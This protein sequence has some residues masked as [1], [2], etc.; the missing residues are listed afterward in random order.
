M[1]RVSKYTS[2]VS[3]SDQRFYSSCIINVNADG[4][5]YCNV[6][7]S[8]LP[9]KT[10]RHRIFKNNRTDKW[11]L[12]SKTKSDLERLYTELHKSQINPEV[13]TELVIRYSF[14]G[15]ARWAENSDGD[16]APNAVDPGYEWSDRDER[17]HWSSEVGYSVTVA[18][19]AFEKSTTHI[20]GIEP[21][22]EYKEYENNAAAERL[23]SFVNSS[24]QFDPKQ[25]DVNE[26][27]YTDDRAEFFSNILMQICRMRRKFRDIN[28]NPEEVMN[29]IEAKGGFLQ[30]TQQ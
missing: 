10:E 1:A 3:V 15:Y 13:H 9:Y 29:V 7:S 14:A 25:D 30:L 21:V 16:I 8:W 23:N 28:Q 22:I 11:Q 5:F 4:E 12:F 27:P 26:I 24:P 17:H 18:A 2:A 20:E 19:G 6:L